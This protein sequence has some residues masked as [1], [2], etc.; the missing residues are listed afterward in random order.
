MTR[1]TYGNNCVGWPLRYVRELTDL[2]DSARD[3]QRKTFLKHVD[4]ENMRWLEHGL[5]YGG[6]SLE[7]KDDYHVRYRS[8]RLF[9]QRVYFFVW[10]GIEYVFGPPPVL[11][12]IMS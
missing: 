10:S 3:I 7:M 11:E 9:G 4:L 8:G 1:L 2:C 6:G 5:G 12:R